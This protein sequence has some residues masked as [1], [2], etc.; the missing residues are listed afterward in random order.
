MQRALACTETF[1]S[2][3][4]WYEKDPTNGTVRGF[5]ARS[6]VGGY[7]MKLLQRRLPAKK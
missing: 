2:N 7:Y 3:D 6:V 5:Q 1:Y 4:Y